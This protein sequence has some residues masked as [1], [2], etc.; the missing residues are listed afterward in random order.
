MIKLKLR[1]EEEIEKYKCQWC[2]YDYEE[3]RETDSD[4]LFPAPDEEG[5][6]WISIKPLAY[7][8]DEELKS[9]WNDN[10]GNGVLLRRG[11]DIGDSIDVISLVDGE[12]YILQQNKYFVNKNKNQEK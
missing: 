3:Y 1:S 5:Y 2:I 12:L 10:E 6:D 9:L 7:L 4:V 11:E 8:T